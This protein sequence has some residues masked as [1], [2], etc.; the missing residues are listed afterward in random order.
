MNLIFFLPWGATGFV[1]RV[2]LVNESVLVIKYDRQIQNERSLLQARL[3][4]IYDQVD[5]T[6]IEKD[7]NGLAVQWNRLASSKEV[8]KG[9]EDTANTVR[10]ERSGE[11]RGS[12]W[13]NI[14]DTFQTRLQGLYGQDNS[15]NK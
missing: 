6:F 10:K 7:L 12:K 3:R 4:G 2:G 11:D 8:E 13:Q 5:T 15:A 1:P 9:M 14:S